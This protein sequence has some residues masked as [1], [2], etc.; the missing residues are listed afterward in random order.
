M[1]Q[2][3]MS[4]FFINK[5]RKMLN[6]F[7][8]LDFGIS[9]SGNRP[10]IG[11]QIKYITLSP[12][13]KSSCV[14][15]NHPTKYANMVCSNQSRIITFFFIFYNVQKKKY[16]SCIKSLK[17]ESMRYLKNIANA[18]R[19][20]GV[21]LITSLQKPTSDSIPTDIKAHLTTKKFTL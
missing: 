5:T 10:P 9:I 12:I 13:V 2:S 16:Y 14:L 6:F 8:S 11:V 17:Y 3:P 21:F 7:P 18:G 15:I 19:S 4:Y 1:R 20:S